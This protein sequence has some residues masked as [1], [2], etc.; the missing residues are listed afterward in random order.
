MSESKGMRWVKKKLRQIERQISTLT[1]TVDILVK[2]HGG[3][4]LQDLLSEPGTMFE[5]FRMGNDE[6]DPNG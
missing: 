2:M 4:D 1:K 5:T 6:N 3:N